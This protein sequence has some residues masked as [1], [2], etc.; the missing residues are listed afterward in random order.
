MKMFLKYLCGVFIL[1]SFIWSIDAHA[2]IIF[3]NSCS[4]SDVQL[5][6]NSAN[7]RDI[8]SVP[9]GSCLWTTTVS[10]TK[11]IIL[12]GAG[13]NA[14]IINCGS[15]PECVSMNVPADS[16]LDSATPLW[17]ITGF[18]FENGKVQDNGQIVIRG[19]RNWRIDHN[20]FYNWQTACAVN[21]INTSYGVVDHNYFY[22]DV[23]GPGGTGIAVHVSE[24]VNN[25]KG[26]ASW[27][28]P[29]V[30]GTANAVC[31]EDNTITFY[32]NQ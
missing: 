30:W 21:V 22:Q 14:T 8:V 31:I 18:T 24:S 3:A 23:A 11:Q 15:L 28:T 26:F 12:M 7:S 1:L 27:Q 20:Y 25:D 32:P 17:K 16:S 6:I 5:A 19:G 2:A 29:L 13:I 9:S 10:S 4:N